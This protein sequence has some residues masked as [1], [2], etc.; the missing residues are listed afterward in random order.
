MPYGQR[1]KLWSIDDVDHTGNI[2]MTILMARNEAEAREK[3]EK[4]HGGFLKITQI[5]TCLAISLAMWD[6][7]NGATGYAKRN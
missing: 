7:A 5:E 3:F 4:M 2:G 1:N 6:D